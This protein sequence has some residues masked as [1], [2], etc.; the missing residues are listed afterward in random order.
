MKK[1][2]VN[3][4]WITISVSISEIWGLQPWILGVNFMI[5][6]IKEQPHLKVL[7][8]IIQNSVKSEHIMRYQISHCVNT[9]IAPGIDFSKIII[10]SSFKI[11]LTLWDWK[12]CNP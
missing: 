12:T 7:L 10:Y 8:R 3:M 2:S 1:K 9:G 4:Q 11:M 6:M 5:L